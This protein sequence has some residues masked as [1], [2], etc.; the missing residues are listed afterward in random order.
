M[1]GFERG[2]VRYLSELDVQSTVHGRHPSHPKLH[3]ERKMVSSAARS[4]K[5]DCAR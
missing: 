5:E 3:G 1:G 4:A 2:Q